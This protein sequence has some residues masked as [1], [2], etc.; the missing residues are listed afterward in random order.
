MAS[1][2]TFFVL[3][4]HSSGGLSKL[5]FGG[6]MGSASP[7]P[8]GSSRKEF[9]EQQSYYQK[10]PSGGS[11]KAPPHKRPEIA[12]GS[13]F[14]VLKLHSP[15]GLSELDF[16]GLLGSASPEPQERRSQNNKVIT[17]SCLLEALVGVPPTRGQKWLLEALSL[18]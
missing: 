11:G 7:E 18:Y 14:S 2:S 12:S 8:Q 4:L 3:K 1:G 15:G 5:D 10:L 13:T 17:K 16:G 9:P 6:L